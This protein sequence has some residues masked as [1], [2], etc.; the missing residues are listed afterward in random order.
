MGEGE[1][2]NGK[3]GLAMREIEAGAP[4]ICRICF[5]SE[6]T[7]GNLLIQP[8]SCRGSVAHCHQTCLQQWLESKREVQLVCELCRGRLRIQAVQR[9]SWSLCVFAQSF[10]CMV[11]FLVVPIQIVLIVIAAKVGSNLRNH[12]NLYVCPRA[13]IEASLYMSSLGCLCGVLLTVVASILL[14]VWS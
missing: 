10:P 1:T 8:C 12:T 7:E 6:S 2:E 4:E 3:R 13:V 14:I 11:L 5:S 9:K